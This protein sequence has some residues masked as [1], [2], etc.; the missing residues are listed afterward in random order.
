VAS[1]R[2]NKQAA[3]PR[4][5]AILGALE[6]VW[7]GHVCLVERRS[8]KREIIDGQWQFA[9]RDLA[10][11]FGRPSREIDLLIEAERFITGSGRSP[12]AASALAHDLKARIL[13]GPASGALLNAY[14]EVVTALTLR[15]A[16]PMRYVWETTLFAWE[17]LA[18]A[19][20]RL[21]RLAPGVPGHRLLTD[22]LV[23]GQSTS[24]DDYAVVDALPAVVH[25]LKEQFG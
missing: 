14:C 10:S 18:L 5:E 19:E 24:K 4:R 23:L 25:A 11:A 8:V 1:K 22:I 13:N 16:G 15:R 9:E 21:A 3:G 12:A 7:M 17:T 20:S 2:S 6:Q